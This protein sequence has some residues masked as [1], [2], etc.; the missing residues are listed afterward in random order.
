M[1]CPHGHKFC[2]DFDI[3]PECL[4]CETHP[5]CEV[6]C[7]EKIQAQRFDTCTSC[8]EH[9][10]GDVGPRYSYGIYAGRLCTKCCSGYRDNCGLDQSQGK[11]EDTDEFAYGGYD[12]VYGEDY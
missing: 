2:D 9:K 10:P 8:G 5:E 6:A 4:S 11:V 7:D 1:N 3:K 12:A